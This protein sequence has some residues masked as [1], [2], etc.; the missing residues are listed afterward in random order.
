MSIFNNPNARRV[1]RN[2]QARDEQ[3]TR[4]ARSTQGSDKAGYGELDARS[5][6]VKRLSGIEEFV[7]QTPD[8]RWEK[9]Q[10]LKKA[11]ANG[12]YRPSARDIADA[13]LRETRNN[14]RD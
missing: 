7:S 9:V 3:K 2:Q 14:L 11:V 6:K 1:S 13:M 4:H 12:R 5:S 8:V 10:A